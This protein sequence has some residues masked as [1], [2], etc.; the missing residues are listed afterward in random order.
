MPVKPI[1]KP[2][3]VIDIAGQ[4]RHNYYT[5]SLPRLHRWQAYDSCQ[6][7]RF[8]KTRYAFHRCKAYTQQGSGHGNH[9][10][11]NNC[12]YDRTIDELSTD[13]QKTLNAKMRNSGH[14]DT[15]VQPRQGNVS[16]Y[17]RRQLDAAN[18]K[19]RY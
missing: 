7:R 4:G 3:D 15:A 5:N 6:M 16:V 12:A 19:Q 11:I 8:Q 13:Q 18:V 14:V 17:R 1:K 9:A 10:L 2:A